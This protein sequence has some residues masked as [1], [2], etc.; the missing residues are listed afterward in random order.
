MEKIILII[1]TALGSM[2]EK[3]AHIGLDVVEAYI[4]KS[5]TLIDNDVF[6]KA[7]KYVKSWTPKN[8]G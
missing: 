5:T 7:V 4:I 8:E 3:Y 1:L 2:G 6:Y